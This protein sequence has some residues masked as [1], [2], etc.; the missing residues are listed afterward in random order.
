MGG[1]HRTDPRIPLI[2]A[3][4][5]LVMWSAAASAQELPPALQLNEDVTITYATTQ[6]GTYATTQSGTYAT[7]QSG[8]LPE[9]LQTMLPN[10]GKIRSRLLFQANTGM[11][12]FEAGDGSYTLIQDRQHQRSWTI[13]GGTQQTGS[14]SITPGDASAGEL[15][16]DTG[17]D[18]DYSAR[19]EGGVRE[20][21][22]VPCVNWRVKP[23]DDPQDE[24]MLICYSANGLDLRVEQKEDGGVTIQQA[25]RVQYG[26]LDPKLF[27]PPQMPPTDFLPIASYNY[28]QERRAHPT[29]LLRKGP[30]PQAY[31]VQAVPAG[32]KRLG[33][34]SGILKLWGLLAFPPRPVTGTERNVPCLVFAHG[35]FAFDNSDFEA[36]RPALDRG[37]AV[38]MPTFRGENGNGGS[39]EYM[40][41]EVDDLAAAVRAVAKEPGINPG[42]L[43]VL[44]HSVGGGLADLLAL[45]PDVP[46]RLSGSVGSLYFPGQLRP[47]PKDPLFSPDNSWERS[48][49]TDGSQCSTT[50]SSA[51]RLFRKSGNH[52]QTCG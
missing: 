11:S 10:G 12:R 33:Y 39:F 27:E 48:L 31:Q 50:C 26:R 51:C 35:G 32:A 28:L 16:G 41:G 3:F 21:A 45:Y 5:P 52:R 19:R 42:R 2:V 23:Q 6:S 36:L 47:D 8:A 15:P 40:F 30:S 14:V 38:F 4:L 9:G 43:Y 25:E 20:V 34:S 22:G 7:T 13:T 37:F 17:R 44:G 18:V 29:K 46:V 24:G 1:I 49:R